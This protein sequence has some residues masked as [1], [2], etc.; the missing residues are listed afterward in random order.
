MGLSQAARLVIRNRPTIID[1]KGRQIGG[2]LRPEQLLTRL[3]AD[4]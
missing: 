3:A 4:D 2:Y 1:S